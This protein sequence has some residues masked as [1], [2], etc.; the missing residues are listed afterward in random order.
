[1][2]DQDYGRYSD[3]FIFIPEK[4]QVIRIA[5]GCGDNLLWEDIENGYVDYIYY[6]QHELNVDIPE[7]DGGMVLLEEP[8]RDKYQCMADCI[9]D[10]LDMAYGSRIIRYIA[11][12]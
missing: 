7:V 6:A 3:I 1:M 12:A 4:R 9:P 2:V 10:V 8:L 5:E 11:L